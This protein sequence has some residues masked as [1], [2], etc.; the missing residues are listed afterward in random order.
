MEMFSRVPAVKT[1]CS[2][3]TLSTVVSPSTAQS[4]HTPS[5]NVHRPPGPPLPS[6]SSSSSSSSTTTTTFASTVAV[7]AMPISTTLNRSTPTNTNTNDEDLVYACPRCDDTFTSHIDLIGHLRTYRTE[8]GKPATGSPKYTR[9]I[10]LHCPHCSRTFMHRMG[11]FGYMRIHE[12]EIDHSPDTPTMHGLTHTPQSSVLIAA[13]TTTTTTIT[14]THT[15]V[16][17]EVADFSCPQCPRASTSRIGLVGHLRINHTERGKP[18]P[19]APKYTCRTRLLCTR[20][21]SYCMDLLCHM[22]I[23]ESGIH[24]RLEKPRTSCTPTMPSPNHTP[25][26]STLTT[27]EKAASSR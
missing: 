24:R 20:T 3:R 27:E 10:R 18:V 15:N 21:F 26:R 22:R 6:S 1:N 19:G 4:L 5:T 13:T 2:V 23:H 14:T 9:R 12:S 17:I 25:S 7:A 16:D 8:T 11:L